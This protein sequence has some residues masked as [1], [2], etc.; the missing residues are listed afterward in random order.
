MLK[1]ALHLRQQ[2]TPRKVAQ[3]PFFP[4][5]LPEAPPRQGFLEHEDYFRLSVA[6][7]DYLRGP[8]VMGY[9]LGMREG[10]IL[11]LTWDRIDTVHWELRLRSIDTKT[12]QPRTLP[13]TG[14]LL[15]VVRGQRKLRDTQFPECPYVFF[16]TRRIQGGNRKNGGRTE[17]GDPI[18]SI[19]DAWHTACEE[20]GLAGLLFHDLRRT[21]ARNMRKAGVHPHTIMLITGHRT[22]S[23]FRRYDIQDNKDL[24]EAANRTAAYLNEQLTENGDSLVTKRA[25][26]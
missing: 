6:L 9:H 25:V 19:R 8:F 12:G 7:P 22:D 23:M 13:L 15:N 10:E 5:N 2:C 26:K 17:P 11:N 16:Y 4:L 1:R 24:R 21:A 20:V 14:D 18:R 3:L